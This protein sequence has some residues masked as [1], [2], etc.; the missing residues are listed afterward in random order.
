MLPLSG[1]SSQATRTWWECRPF[2]PSRHLDQAEEGFKP[3]ASSDVLNVFE[4][5]D[6]KDQLFIG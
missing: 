2:A 3:T 6:G 1:I 4:L 5:D